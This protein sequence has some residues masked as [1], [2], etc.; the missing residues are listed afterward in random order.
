MKWLLAMGAALCAAACGNE[1]SGSD[2]A[3][4]PGLREDGT[5]DPALCQN[6][7]YDASGN[8]VL[9]G[10]PCYDQWAASLGGILGGLQGSTTLYRD[11]CAAVA[12]ARGLP[13][14]WSSQPTELAQAQAA[15]AAVDGSS[16]PDGVTCSL[17]DAEGCTV[18]VACESDASPPPID[19]AAYESATATAF[20]ACCSSA[21]GLDDPTAFLPPTQCVPAPGTE[22]CLADLFDVS[23]LQSTSQLLQTTCNVANEFN[24]GGSSPP[25]P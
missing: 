23:S 2:G 9:T 15:C 18:T 16:A 24:G 19:L 3:P 25:F 7:A 11:A 1:V 13:D 14:T 20:S 4:E 10:D 22:A 12:L 17:L 5:V 8:P 6:G 21:E